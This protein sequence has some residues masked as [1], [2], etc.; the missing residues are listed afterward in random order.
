MVQ[1]RYRPGGRPPDAY[2]AA[3][4][5]R[6]LTF[7]VRALGGILDIKVLASKPET[8]CIARRWAAAWLDFVLLFILL[9]C[10]DSI[11]SIQ[12]DN[13]DVYV[14][15]AI[16]ILYFPVFERLIGAT[17]GKLVFEIRVVDDNGDKPTFFQAIIRG[18][19][20]AL[21]VNPILFG[22]VPAGIFAMLSEHHQRAGDRLAGTYVLKVVHLKFGENLSERIE[23]GKSFNHPYVKFS[24]A[25]CSYYVWTSI[26][27]IKYMKHFWDRQKALD[28]AERRI[29]PN[30][31]RKADA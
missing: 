2:Y 29:R 14:W 30:Q 22:G 28:F 15:L 18:I 12:V 19:L 11:D 23:E 25:H 26:F 7:S 24:E 31:S 3:L 6:R 16:V 9:L 5:R 1:V 20:R 4:R 10:L 8:S 21:E 17:I 13:L 27:F